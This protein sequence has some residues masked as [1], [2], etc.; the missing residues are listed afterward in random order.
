M[1][2][3]AVQ[4]T[5]REMQQDF[6]RP[7]LW[8]VLICAGL[9]LALAGAFGTGDVL[10]PVPLALYW[11]V[12]AVLTYGTGQ[13]VS[14]VLGRLA[15]GYATPVRLGIVGLGA[16]VA[17]TALLIGIN[18]AL[19]EPFFTD[20]S[21]WWRF[22]GTSFVVVFLITVAINYAFS[23][24][25]AE[26][27]SGQQGPALLSRLPIEKRGALISLSAV[28]HY[29][30]V[31]TT[32]GRELLLMR[33]SDAIQETAPQQGL[34]IHRSHWI[35]VQHVAR[36]TRDGQKAIVTMA[37]GRALPASRANLPALKQ[38]GLVPE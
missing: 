1:K 20:T 22:V 19:F 32:K 28:D 15:A 25:G 17:I 5:L 14:G 33:L 27:T 18:F 4:L 6:S 36:V 11:I 24:I 34:Q 29:V 23:V 2:R 3:T 16:A 21:A 8:V 37:D 35:A 26:Q 10:R 38:A 13:L 30:E 31:V 12:V 7:I 9:V